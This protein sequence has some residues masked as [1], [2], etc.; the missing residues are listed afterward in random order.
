MAKVSV[1]GIDE[2]INSAAIKRVTLWLSG[3]QILKGFI[4]HVSF[5]KG[6]EKPRLMALRTKRWLCKPKTAYVDVIRIAAIQIDK[7]S[8]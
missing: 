3:G 2:A 6:T 7:D 8:L 5:F 4:L 1:D